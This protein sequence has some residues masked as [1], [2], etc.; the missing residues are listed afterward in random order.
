MV[1]SMKPR[2][3]VHDSWRL[4]EVLAD[5]AF[6]L[7]TSRRDY[8]DAGIRALSLCLDSAPAFRTRGPKS[9]E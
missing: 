8:I 4:V 6:G 7:E 1:R 2:C 3:P 9:R 5:V